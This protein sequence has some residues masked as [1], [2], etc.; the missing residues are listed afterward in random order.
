[1]IIKVFF[2]SRKRPEFENLNIIPE[3]DVMQS[4]ELSNIQVE[5]LILINKE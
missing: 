1:M 2:S 4:S 3:H 5:I